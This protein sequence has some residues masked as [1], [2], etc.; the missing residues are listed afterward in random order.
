[1]AFDPFP[2]TAAWR[3]QGV[4]EGFEVVFFDRRGPEHLIEGSTSG[5]E[6][7]EPWIVRYEITVDERWCTRS[8]RV[9]GRSALGRF[10][11]RIEGDGAGHWEVD[12]A[13]L[14]AI[15]GCLDV[16]L[17]S[18]ACTNTLPVHRVAPD[19]GQH[20]PAPAVYVRSLDLRVERLEQDYTRLDDDG[21]RRRYDY[22]SPADDFRCVLTYDRSGLVVD[23]PGIALRAR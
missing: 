1:M 23:Y 16:D 22:V 17:E 5:V 11:R 18:S 6:D 15:D 20:T 2:A 10:E 21:T 19:V 14:P 13:R 4:Q 12:G 9:W 7:G 3:H 8:A